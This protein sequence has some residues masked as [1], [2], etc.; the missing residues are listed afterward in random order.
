MLIKL[1][2][3]VSVLRYNSAFSVDCV[4]RSGGLYIFWKSSSLCNILSYS[5]DHIDVVITE[6]SCNWRFTGYY[7]HSERVNKRLS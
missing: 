3:Y 2:K 4:G 1:K 6:A 7:G 5:R